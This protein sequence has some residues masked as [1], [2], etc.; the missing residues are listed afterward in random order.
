MVASSFGLSHA[1]QDRKLPR[2]GQV[3]FVDRTTAEPYDEAFRAGLRALGYVEG[4]NVTIVARYA[5]GDDAQV[6]PLVRE[7]V[8]L[9]VDVL[10]VSP[11]AVQA[12]KEATTSVPIV[13]AN[14]LDAVESG[15]VASL[16]RP[17]GNL[18]G[19]T[20]QEAATDSKRLELARELVPAVRR[21]AVLFD[22][23]SE[24]SAFP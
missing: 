14:M 1:Q 10:L 18:T 19:L 8:A 6:R 13:C 12:A 16:S 3:F 2:V 4:E 11:S 23:T 17:G 21:L 22:A 7:L 15:L 24:S 20:Y 9:P 5:N